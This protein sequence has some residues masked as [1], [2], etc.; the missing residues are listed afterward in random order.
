MTQ[1]TYVAV[2]A[3]NERSAPLNCPRCH[4]PAFVRWGSVLTS[5]LH[6]AGGHFKRVNIL[7]TRRRCRSCGRLAIQPL[8]PSLRRPGPK[9][10]L[11]LA[12]LAAMK[13]L[14]AEGMSVFQIAMLTGL[15]PANVRRWLRADPNADS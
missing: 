3:R 9:A 13:A 10:T 4:E 6:Y 15:G 5:L 14:Q 11:T 1:T 2:T 7:R 8:P 12:S